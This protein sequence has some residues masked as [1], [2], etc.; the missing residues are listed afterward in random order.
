MKQSTISRVF[1]KSEQWVKWLVLCSFFGLCKVEADNLLRGFKTT[2]FVSASNFAIESDLLP[3]GSL[4]GFLEVISKEFKQYG[5]LHTLRNFQESLLYQES[6]LL[7]AED[8]DIVWLYSKNL[9]DFFEN[10]LDKLNK[11]IIVVCSGNPTFPEGYKFAREIDSYL[12]SENLIHLFI[13]N[14][15]YRGEFQSKVTPIPLGLDYHTRLLSS[16]SLGK[17]IPKT[18]LQQE[19][20]LKGII[21]KL[22]NTT[23]RI[24]NKIF[25]DFSINNNGGNRFGDSRHEIVQILK[26]N[27]VVDL[28][29]GFID[30]TKVWKI[31]GQRAFDISPSGSGADCYWTWEGLAL[32]CIVITKTSFLDPLFEGL[33][34]VIVDNYSEVTQENLQKWLKQYGD[35]F[36]NPSY[37]ERLTHK[38]W[39]DKIRKVQSDYRG[40]RSNS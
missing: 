12:S 2:H 5:L 24:G 30:R 39:M 11:K 8:G 34:V 18:P 32:G 19:K 33:P 35:V 37:R 15:N 22:Q 36:H 21:K 14:N 3:Y 20:D 4:N 17:A 26:K 27:E 7:S 9:R 28:N 1:K 40:K 10:T 25:C 13:Q 6:L 38:Y 23:S 31:K 16:F 29:S